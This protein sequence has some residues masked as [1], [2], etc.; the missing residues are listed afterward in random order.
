MSLKYSNFLNSNLDWSDEEITTKKKWIK[1]EELSINWENL[2]LLWDE[3]FILLEVEQALRR[4]GGGDM[5]GY[6]NGNPWDV[7]KRELEREI[8]KEKVKS[9][10][11][12]VCRVNGIDYEK[13]IDKNADVKITTENI[14]RTFKVGAK[15]GIKID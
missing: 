15:V 3:I 14:E 7:T 13:T 11:K 4:R 5:Q 6:I 8:G 12:L 2:D 10:I 9:F 1:W